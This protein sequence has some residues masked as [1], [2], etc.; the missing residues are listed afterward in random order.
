MDRKEKACGFCGTEGL[1]VGYLVDGYRQYPG[2]RRW[3]RTRL[4]IC[5]GC[6]T[7][8][9][10]PETGCEI[11]AARKR[12]RLEWR[13]LA[14]RGH[15]MDPTP[16]AACGQSVIRNSDPLLKRVT[17]SLACDS[18]LSRSRNDREGNKGSGEPCEACGEVI[19]TGRADSRY[20]GSACR[21]K[22]Y[23]QRNTHA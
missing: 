3:T 2:G 6:Y 12:P 17:C 9:F 4:L 21:Q 7:A 18:S 14:G 19:T 8:G 22:A 23:R 20:C 11:P 10:D 13:Q 15:V 1:D 16:C 5:A